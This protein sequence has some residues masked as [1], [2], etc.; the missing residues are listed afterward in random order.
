MLGRRWGEAQPGSVARQRCKSC[1]KGMAKETTHPVNQCPLTPFE[2]CPAP[3]DL[4]ARS[5]G[6][7]GA[8]HLGKWLLRTHPFRP[9]SCSRSPCSDFDGSRP[10]RASPVPAVPLLFGGG[11]HLD[12]MLTLLYIEENVFLKRTLWCKYNIIFYDK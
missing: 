8:P 7:R 1:A 12:K 11:E 2:R 10:F 4:L 6:L 9:C 3:R 5:F